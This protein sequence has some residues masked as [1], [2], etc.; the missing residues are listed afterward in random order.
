M[1]Q[2]VDI[3]V[4]PDRHSG[5]RAARVGDRAQPPQL[6]DQFDIDLVDSGGDGGVELLGG[7]ADPGEDDPLRRDAGG[8]GAPQL[9][10][11]DDVGAGAEQGEE[12]QD[13]QVRVCLDGIADERRRR[14]KRIAEMAIAGAQRAGGIDVERRA[15]RRGDVRHRHAFDLQGAVAVREELI[16]SGRPWGRY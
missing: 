14:R 8:E 4:D 3:R 7:L 13:G 12:P 6:R 16:H 1:G 15:D 2:R 5:G 11:R 9:A 10:L